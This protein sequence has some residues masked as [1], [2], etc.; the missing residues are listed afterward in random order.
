M[1]NPN[2]GTANISVP[3][4]DAWPVWIGLGFDYPVLK[5]FII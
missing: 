1:V 5:F 3:L 4:L 2:T